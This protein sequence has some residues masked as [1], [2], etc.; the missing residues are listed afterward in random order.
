MTRAASYTCRSSASASRRPSAAATSS[1]SWRASRSVAR[2][3]ARW[4]ASRTSSSRR[5]ASA[6]PSRGASASQDAATARRAVASRRPP[7]ASLRSG[8]SR[9]RSSPWRSARSAHRSRSSGRR[10]GAWLRQSARAV[11][12]RAAVRPRSPARWRASRSPR[13]TFRSSPAVLRACCGVRTEWSRSMPRS[14]T[15]YQRRSAR[16]ATALSS[17]PS[18]SRSRSRSLRGDSSPRP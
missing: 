7:R 1:C 6:R 13:W 12:R 16:A 18:C 10:L 15:G 9:N 17:R 2:P 4:R 5:R 8:S 3:V 11:V 14:Q